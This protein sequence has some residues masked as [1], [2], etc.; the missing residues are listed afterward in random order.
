[1]R[2]ERARRLA[3]STDS[4]TRLKNVAAAILSAGKPGCPVRQSRSSKHRKAPPPVARR[5]SAWQD[6]TLAGRQGCLPPHRIA[7]RAPCRA[8]TSMRICAT[9]LT[10]AFFT[11]GPLCAGERFSVS[12][13]GWIGSI[14]FSPDG[15]RL[16]VGCADSSARVLEV[17]T[18]KEAALLRGHQ[19]YVA[20]VAFAPDGRTLATASYDHTARVWDL[21]SRR[22]RHTL[23][24][25]RGAVMSV[26]FSPDGR[27]L[28]T[29]SIDATV[30]LWNAATGRLRATLRGHKSW[31][32]SVAFSADN[33]W[34]V[35]GSSDS[36]IKLWSVRAP[37][38]AATVDATDAEV[39][40][41]ANPSEGQAH[42]AGLRYGTR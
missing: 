11:I 41:E 40:Y 35:S 17:E 18:G 22:T 23:R 15:K 26:A 16:A 30:K 5:C 13:P 28:A 2:D 37:R 27:W 32:N 7:P 4:R 21:E 1:M 6:A 38:L 34:L 10:V 42:C 24:G 3:E 8:R 36:T 20:S 9:A 33:Q 12:M 14:S 19:D 39:R 31:I 25:H 29:G